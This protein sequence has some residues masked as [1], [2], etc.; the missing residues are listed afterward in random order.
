MGTIAIIPPY[1]N[2]PN[3]PSGSYKQLVLLLSQT[4]VSVPTGIILS[5]TLGVSIAYDKIGVGDYRITA[6][7][8]FTLDKT[9]F[10]CNNI[11]KSAGDGIYVLVTHEEINR[12]RVQTLDAG[13]LNVE[14]D[15][16]F[17]ICIEIRVYN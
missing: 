8:K 2:E 4:T 13:L 7:G 6:V 1:I 15:T 11:F 9:W 14:A 3:P 12:I 17:P 5:N 10:Q 16:E